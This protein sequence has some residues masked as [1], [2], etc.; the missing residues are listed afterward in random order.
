[1]RR[2]VPLLVV[3]V[4]VL[5]GCGS[6]GELQPQQYPGA[7]EQLLTRSDVE[8]QAAG[9]PQAELVTWWRGSQFAERGAFLRGF[10]SPVI[11]RLS[12]RPDLDRTLE[13]FSG[14]IRVTRPEIVDVELAGRTATVFT[15]LHMHQPIG[16]KRFVTATR[17]QAFAMVQER[18]RW[19]LAD[20]YFFKM[21]VAPI[22][23]QPASS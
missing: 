14:S 18:G 13:Y 1:M 16:A 9:T 11:R 5:A 15:M 10:A 6:S 22:A 3:G 21:V 2:G 17:P 23:K 7:A 12:A 8:R 20:D 4:L 19:R